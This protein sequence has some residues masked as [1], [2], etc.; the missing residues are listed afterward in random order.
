M[1][2]R[3][4]IEK[5]SPYLA[6]GAD[7]V[8][9]SGGKFLRG[10]QTSGLLLGKKSLIQAAWRNASPHQAFARGMKVSKEDVIGVLAAL[11]VWFEHRDPAEELAPLERRSGGY[12]RPARAARRDH[13]GD[14][15]RRAW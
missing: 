13:R 1:R 3:S 8:I 5:P 11:E 10:P 2:R 12:R 14:C 15:R 6:R 4:I 7:M 9:Y